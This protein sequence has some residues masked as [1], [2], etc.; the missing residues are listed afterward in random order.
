MLLPRRSDRDRQGAAG[1]AR[2]SLERQ[3][4]NDRVIEESVRREL[5]TSEQNSERDRQI[6]RGGLLG[7]SSGGEIDDDPVIWPGKPRVDYRPGDAMGALANRSIGHADE[8]GRGQCPPGN[9]DLHVDRHGFDADEGKGLEAGEHVIC[10][11][12]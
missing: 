5:A 11:I 2:R 12:K 8:H 3:L 1:R 4:A 6:K 7:K 9:V 10:S